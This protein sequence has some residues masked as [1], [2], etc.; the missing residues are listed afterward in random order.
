[1]HLSPAARAA[2][3]HLPGS[4]PGRQRSPVWSPPPSSPKAAAPSPGVTVTTEDGRQVKVP[5]SVLRAAVPAG[6]PEA[7]QL[8]VF[9]AGWGGVDMAIKLAK[10]G[11]AVIVHIKNSS[12]GF[13]KDALEE[14]LRGMPGGSHLEMRSTVDGVNLIAVGSKYNSTKTVFHFASEGAGSTVD[15]VPYTTQ[16]PDEN[17]NVLT[18]EVSRP[19]LVS[20]YFLKFNKVDI[21][22]QL[23]QHE[24]GLEM[25][26]VRKGENAGKFRLM[27]TIKGVTAIDVMLAVKSHNHETHRI[28]T[29]TTKEFIE[30]LAE[31]P[32]DN[33]LDG[34]KS[35]PPLKSRK[36]PSTDKVEMP[37][38]GSVHKL[39]HIGHI[40]ES[41]E[42]KP[43]EVDQLIQLRCAVCSKKTST[44][45]SAV[46]CNKAPVCGSVKRECF[47]SHCT[48]EFPAGGPKRR[49]SHEP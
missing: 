12:A 41:R 40:S 10:Q 31:E 24:L 4:S 34:C 22:D 23:R 49:R 5:R 45:C 21:H 44:Y 38:E 37:A 9:D 26:W 14:Q 17:G 1:M 25:K 2:G 32:I 16:W 20:R 42:L 33:E 6:S 28:R 46:G 3:S 8:F 43:G 15:G 19:A 47:S 30:L 7:G 48:G 36:R 11:F 27:T 13:P 18:R 29:K 39:K 35:R